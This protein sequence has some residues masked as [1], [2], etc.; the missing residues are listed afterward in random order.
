MGRMTLN[1]WFVIM[2]PAKTVCMI[3]RH[4]IEEPVI[5]AL[6]KIIYVMIATTRNSTISTLAG[7]SIKFLTR[8]LGRTRPSHGPA[9]A[10]ESQKSVL[11]PSTRLNGWKPQVPVL[12][13]IAKTL[14]LFDMN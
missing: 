4:V 9:K 8:V 5:A 10:G 2:G 11:A 6:T 12:E 14:G 7:F 1:V 3:V 13:G